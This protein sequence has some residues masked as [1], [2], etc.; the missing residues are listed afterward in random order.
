MG[1]GVAA[2]LALHPATSA[3]TLDDLFALFALARELSGHRDYVIVGSLS[4]LGLADESLVPADMAMSNDIDGFT[5]ADP[6]RIFDL[7]TTLGADSPFHAAHGYFLD[8]VSPSLP[9]LPDGWEGRLNRAERDGLRL[10][11]LDPNDAAVSKYARGEPR[12]QRWIRSGLAHGLI[13]LPIVEARVRQTL[14]L[15]EE[16]ERRVREA[17]EQDRAWVAGSKPSARARS[18]RR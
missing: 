2:E 18:K 13:S 3:V 5:Q 11:F 1:D 16:E 7:D 15:D 10:W 8:P 17:I 9:S 14:F 6:G 12:D 4:I